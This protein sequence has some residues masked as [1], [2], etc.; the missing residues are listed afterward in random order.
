MTDSIWLNDANL[1]N[2]LIKIKKRKQYFYNIL[3]DFL[4]F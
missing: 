4:A 2:F 3:K 1:M